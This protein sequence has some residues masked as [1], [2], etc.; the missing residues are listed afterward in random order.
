MALNATIYKLH[1]HIA[2]MDRPYYHAHALTVA[3]HPSEPVER[4]ME[5]VL[6]F[7]LNADEAL[8]FGIGLSTEDELALW[9]IDLTGVIQLL[10]DVGLPDEND[11]RKACGR[12]QH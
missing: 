12:A 9:R 3:L 1:L 4:M 11:M 5:R 7:A 6:A 2:D 8:N 10:I